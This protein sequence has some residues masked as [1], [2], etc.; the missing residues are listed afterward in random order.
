MPDKH[1]DKS[2]SG[3]NSR[4]LS[5]SHRLNSV[6]LLLKSSLS[7]VFLSFSAPEVAYGERE[8]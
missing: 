2:Y 7:H 1:A 5:L 4:H 8:R 3:H 6:L